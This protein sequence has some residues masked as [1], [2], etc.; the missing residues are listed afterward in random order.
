MGISQTPI[1]EIKTA[2]RLCSMRSLSKPKTKLFISP[3]EII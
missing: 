2:F 3:R 1:E